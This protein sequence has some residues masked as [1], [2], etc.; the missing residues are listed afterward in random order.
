M[1]YKLEVPEERKIH[2]VFHV[3]NFKKILG[4]HIASFIEFPPLDYEGILVL[5]PNRILHV[6]SKET[7][8]QGD[9]RVLGKMERITYGGCHMGGR[10]GIATS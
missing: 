7:P 1:D 3:F 5:I 8:K 10:V 9:L 4:Q 2:R 6:L